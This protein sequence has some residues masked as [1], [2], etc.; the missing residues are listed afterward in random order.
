MWWTSGVGLGAA[1]S[2]ATAC[3]N[4]STEATSGGLG[5]RA[6]GSGASFQ[7]RAFPEHPTPP[8]LRPR[9]P[10]DPAARRTTTSL[11]LLPH[12]RGGSGRKGRV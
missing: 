2:G 5:L 6:R 9:Q 4:F 11:S 3:T 1:A 10:S 7:F 12:P 8:H